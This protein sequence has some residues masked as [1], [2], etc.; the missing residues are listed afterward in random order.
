MSKRNRG[1]AWGQEEE[2]AR[3]YLLS[4]EARVCRSLLMSREVTKE[5]AASD[6]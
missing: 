6:S 1:E 2:G 3:A 4:L 5:E